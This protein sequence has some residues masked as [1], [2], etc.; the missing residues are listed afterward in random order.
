MKQLGLNELKKKPIFDGKYHL[1]AT[2]SM[3]ETGKVY[4][5]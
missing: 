4:L 3:S 1:I 5:A 2:I